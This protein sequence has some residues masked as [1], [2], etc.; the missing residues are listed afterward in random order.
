MTTKTKEEILEAVQDRYG[1]IAQ[2]FQSELTVLNNSDSCCDP[3]SGTE[4]CGSDLYDVDLS[5][6]PADV[7]GLSL[8]C[9]DPIAIAS[10]EP[11]QT[12]LDLGSGGGIDCF[13]AAERVGPTGQ[14]IG[15]DMTPAML[16]KANRNKAKLG[17][18]HVEFRQG[19]IEDLPVDNDS[20][21]VIIS[22]CVIN[23]SPDKTAVFQE[24]FRV[25]KPG[26][27]LAVSDM[28]TRGQFTP[29]ERAD[30][31]AWAGCITGAED[32]AEMAAWMRQAG[33]TQVS[34]QQKESPTVELAN[35]EPHVGPAQIFS[36]RITAV[37][38]L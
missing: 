38:P 31:S 12:V 17:V 34:I 23:L 20:V 3:A 28:V 24:A 27:R 29:Q 35:V 25:L 5:Q 37:K 26:G 36:A 14:V 33:F 1:R 16:E 32:V 9:G 18:A 4:Y 13:L 8:G 21:D 30:M 2:N 19:Q 11:G 22:N 7:T 10:L 15:V 6:L